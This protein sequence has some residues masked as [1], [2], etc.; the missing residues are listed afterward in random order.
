LPQG[1]VWW[2]DALNHVGRGLHDASSGATS[3]KPPTLTRQSNHLRA[4]TPFRLAREQR[5]AFAEQAAIEKLL[6]VVSYEVWK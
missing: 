5:G 3:A 6:E 2:Q 4:C 1:N